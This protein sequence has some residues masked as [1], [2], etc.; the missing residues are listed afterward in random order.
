MVDKE[1]ARARRTEHNHPH[2]GLSS[3][4]FWREAKMSGGTFR[5]LFFIFHGL[6]K[7][8]F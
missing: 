6:N 4:A 8:P 3:S 5:Y 7:R 2:D 1:R